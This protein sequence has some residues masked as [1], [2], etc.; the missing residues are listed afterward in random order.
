MMY[1]AQLATSHLATDVVFGISHSISV[2]KNTIDFTRLPD[3][4][5]IRGPHLHCDDPDRAHICFGR[6]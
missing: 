1:A 6:S 3:V 4:P 2:A 5:V